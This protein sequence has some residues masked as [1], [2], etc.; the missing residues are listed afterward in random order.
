MGSPPLATPPG[1]ALT[2]QEGTMTNPPES[3]LSQA[4][5][6]SVRELVFPQ[7]CMMFGTYERK[8]CGEASV[9]GMSRKVRDPASCW[10]SLQLP[11]GRWQKGPALL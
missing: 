10:L 3:L 4:L 7:T 9:R 11:K 5:P 6:P 1:R 2:R 8:V